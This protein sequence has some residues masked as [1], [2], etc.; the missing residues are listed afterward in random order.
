MIYDFS[1]AATNS[2]SMTDNHATNYPTK[3]FALQSCRVVNIL[4]YRGWLQHRQRIGIVQKA[5]LLSEPLKSVSLRMSHCACWKFDGCHY[6]GKYWLRNLYVNVWCENINWHIGEVYFW[7]L[8]SI[9]Q[10]F[11]MQCKYCQFV[12]KI[13][14][15]L[16]KLYYIIYSS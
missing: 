1:H 4:I 13:A 12:L 11:K 5:N 7:N 6:F 16:H 15:L 8:P 2:N 3:F 14:I 9:Y 10:N